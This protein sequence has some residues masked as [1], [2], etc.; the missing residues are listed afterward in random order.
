MI[1]DVLSEAKD[2]IE[3]YQKGFPEV[4]A[5]FTNE[6]QTVL[7]VMGA[8][9]RRF[10]TP[11]HLGLSSDL[12]ALGTAIRQLDLSAIR[13][14]QQR[15]FGDFGELSGQKRQLE[16]AGGESRNGAAPNRA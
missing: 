3:Q 5:P 13:S 11:P 8:L 2:E 15:L 6:I 12:H 10:D 1:S 7:E 16:S 4:Y 9:Q 14:A